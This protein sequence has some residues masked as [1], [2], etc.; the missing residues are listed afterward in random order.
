MTALSLLII[1]TIW[2]ISAVNHD[3]NSIPLHT[4]ETL[5]QYKEFLHSNNLPSSTPPGIKTSLIEARDKYGARCLDGSTPIF[6]YRQGNDTGTTKYN[7]YLQGGGWCSGIINKVS[8]VFTSSCLSRSQ[9][10]YGTTIHDPTYSYFSYG[11]FDTNPVNNPLSYDWNT[12]YVRYCDCSSFVGNNDTITNVT[13]NNQTYSLYFRGFRVLKGAFELLWNEYGLSNATDVL[14]TGSS[15]G[16]LAVYIHADYIKDN[17]VPDGAN[18]MAM[19]DSGYFI[20]LEGYAKVY[21]TFTWIFEQ[22]NGTDTINK[23]CY[24]HFEESDEV[25]KCIFAQETAPFIESRMFAIQ[26]QYDSFQIGAECVCNGNDTLINQY[27]MNLT[28][29]FLKDYINAGNYKDN[30]SGF[31]IS[32]MEHADMAI[33][34]KIVIDGYNSSQT[35]IEWYYNRTTIHDSL[36][37]QNETYPCSFC[38]S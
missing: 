35:Q 9:T 10:S 14:L 34:N 19:P 4:F 11:Y 30:H 23:G 27:G 36:W 17:W 3:G 5:S 31:L 24:S 8:P 32:C 12:I 1:H 26:S 15:A 2:R 37:F 13:H 28:N 22:N 25:N 20:E 29:I 38:C 21:D 7:I 6:Y 33:W 18:F 16:G